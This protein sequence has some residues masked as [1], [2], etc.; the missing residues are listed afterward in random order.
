[1]KN[2]IVF[3]LLIL[4]FASLAQTTTSVISV[5]YYSPDDAKSKNGIVFYKPDSTGGAIG[6]EF[7]KDGFIYLVVGGG[8][9]PNFSVD[10]READTVFRKY[11]K[12]G[13]TYGFLYEY[14]KT[15]SD[16]NYMY[17]NPTK[18]NFGNYEDEPYLIDGVTLKSADLTTEAQFFIDNIFK[19]KNHLA[20]GIVDFIKQTIAKT[21]GL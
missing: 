3:I 11:I 9:M 8:S 14:R 15:I 13:N 7:A 19:N 2:L 10:N 5:G 16:D 1:M 18:P 17:G 6:I 20:I 21:E 12:A 4:S